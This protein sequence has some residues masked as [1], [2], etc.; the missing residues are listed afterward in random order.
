MQ[1]SISVRPA[2]FI[3][4]DLFPATVEKIIHEDTVEILSDQARVIITNDTF[5]AF[6]DG[7]FGTEIL[8]EEYLI[9]FTGSNISGYIVITE[10]TAYKIT[11]TKHC[12]CGSRLRGFFPYPGVPFQIK[13]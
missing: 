4:L 8:I 7:E 2:E 1:Q 9:D 11:R 10:E 5:Y 6:I 12:G 13:R 3:R